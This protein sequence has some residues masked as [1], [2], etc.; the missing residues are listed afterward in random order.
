MLKSGSYNVLLLSVSMLLLAIGIFVINSAGKQAFNN[1]YDPLP[2]TIHAITL[3]DKYDFAGEEIPIQNPDVRERLEREMLV[4]TY[5]HSNTILNLKLGMRYFPVF[6]KIFAE[7]GI[8]DDM[9]Y[10]A[11]AESSLRNVSSPANAKGIWQ[12]KDET[13][14]DYDLEVSNYVDERNN[15]EKS[16]LAAC[17]YLK[18]QKELFGSWALAAAAYNMGPA[19]LQKAMT[20]QKESNYYDLNVS[21]ETNRYVF[22]I[23]AIKEIMKNPEKFGFY[24]GKNEMY[25]PMT[26]FKTI[27]IDSTI[28]NLADFAHQ[29]NMTYRQLKVYNPWMIKTELPNPKHRIYNI[30]VV[31]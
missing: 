29:Q 13:A 11:V 8:P 4:N 25:P 7:Q 24:I 1:R 2:Q 30:K 6:E 14:R 23:V 10:L 22:R 19:G 16:T 20:D 21:D 17:Q 27:E 28:N 5:H 12:F 26:G 9:K 3:A 31:Q 15:L 18:K